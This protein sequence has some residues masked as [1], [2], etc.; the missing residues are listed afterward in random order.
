MPTAWHVGGT[1]ENKERFSE[2]FSFPVSLTA[3]RSVKTES[4]QVSW[5]EFIS[6]CNSVH[7]VLAYLGFIRKDAALRMFLNCSVPAALS[8]Q[9]RLYRPDWTPETSLQAPG[10]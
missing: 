10:V 6:V 3:F 2:D 4:T 1:N 7:I 8:E 9:I 5:S